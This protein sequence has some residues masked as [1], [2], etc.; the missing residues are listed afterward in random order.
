MKKSTDFHAT[1]AHKYRT[2]TAGS[3]AALIL[4]RAAVFRAEKDCTHQRCH[5]EVPTRNLTRCVHCTTFYFS[6]KIIA[7]LRV[8]Q[9]LKFD[10]KHRHDGTLLS[11]ELASRGAPIL[12]LTFTAPIQI[13]DGCIKLLFHLERCRT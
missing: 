8:L 13:V 11:N 7:P 5:Y 1:K 2:P 9:V 6:H 4:R 10:N 3:E 12:Y